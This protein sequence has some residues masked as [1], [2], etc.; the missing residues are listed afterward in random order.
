M[1]ILSLDHQLAMMHVSS[2]DLAHP[3]LAAK[4]ING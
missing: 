4:K 1:K 3:H 2:T